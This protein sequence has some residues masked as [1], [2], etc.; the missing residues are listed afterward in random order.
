MLI[1]TAA[2]LVI[3]ALTTKPYD[4]GVAKNEIHKIQELRTGWSV[5]LTYPMRHETFNRE[6]Q[7]EEKR[8]SITRG[9]SLV[10]LYAT[11]EDSSSPRYITVN[12]PSELSSASILDDSG[13]VISGSFEEVVPTIPNSL[14]S[15]QKWWDSLDDRHF[16]VYFP[17]SVFEKAEVIE[18]RHLPKQKLY[19]N[20]QIYSGGEWGNLLL[21]NI[22]KRSFRFPKKAGNVTM[23]VQGAKDENPDT[24]F[25]DALDFVYDGSNS[26]D[27]VV[28]GFSYVR[29]NRKAFCAY[30][31]LP[32]GLADYTFYDLRQ[33]ADL[34][35]VENLDKL[36]EI[37]SKSDVSESPSFEAFGVK[38]PADLA[39]VAGIAVMLSMQLYFFVYLRKFSGSLKADDP[40]WDVP[41]IGMDSSTLAAGL[42]FT[43][44]LIIPAS[45]LIILSAEAT[46]RFTRGYWR[47]HLFPVS[48]MP[49]IVDLK[50]ALITAAVLLSVYLG[51]LCWKY[52][53]R[54]AI[55]LVEE[56]P[57]IKEVV[58]PHSD[59]ETKTEPKQTQGSSTQV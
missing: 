25:A 40:G 2:A 54:V 44:V 43:T 56:E 31:R 17:T 53:P 34:N 58:A 13:E 59:E 16:I 22:G 1:A 6:E 41:W 5:K 15:F 46:V 23:T 26:V 8:L 27:F 3:V 42:F 18:N 52:R 14:V 30:L 48:S 12:L 37:L 4:T 50:I 35:G 55:R 10:V 7:K 49:W 39:T 21:S 45:A 9:S 11:N 38:F 33:I 29:L 32:E 24:H 57:S 19:A 36:E 28:S 51:V 20:A 47:P